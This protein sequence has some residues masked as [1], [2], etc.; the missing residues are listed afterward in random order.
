M[1][2]ESRWITEQSVEVSHSAPP[3]DP[4]TPPPAVS[5]RTEMKTLNALIVA[6]TAAFAITAATSNTAHAEPGQKDEVGYALVGLEY[7]FDIDGDKKPNK[8][9]VVLLCQVV[10]SS[11]RQM[12]SCEGEG[13]NA[14]HEFYIWMDYLGNKQGFGGGAFYR[15]HHG[16]TELGCLTWAR[17]RSQEI[18]CGLSGE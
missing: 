10:K 11:G 13:S 7:W 15:E 16:E 14:E 4:S 5:T 17:G 3:N 12:Y 2:Q 18:T 6:A 9:D 8:V 1:P